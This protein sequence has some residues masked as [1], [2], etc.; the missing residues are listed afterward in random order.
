MCISWILDTLDEL[1][2]IGRSF[3][4]FSCYGSE[5]FEVLLTLF[6][7]CFLEIFLN[8]LKVLLDDTTVHPSSLSLV[9]SCGETMMEEWEV[10]PFSTLVFILS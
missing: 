4:V 6:V 5:V 10:S 2:F 8:L 9:N 7:A 1:D 3:G